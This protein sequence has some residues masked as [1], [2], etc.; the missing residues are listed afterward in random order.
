[1]DRDFG[2]KCGGRTLWR[3]L[4]VLPATIVLSSLVPL[5]GEDA[6]P[7]EKG[8]GQ[9]A[10]PFLK[11]NCLGCHDDKERSGEVVLQPLVEKGFRDHR[12][13]WRRAERQLAAK[14]MPPEDQPQPDDKEREAFLA[15][16]KKLTSTPD[17]KGADPGRVTVRRLNRAEYSYTVQDLLHVRARPH[18]EF[19][20][21]DAGYGFD[22]I[23]DV[24]TVPPILLERYLQ[25]AE[26]IANEAILDWKPIKV[27]QAATE[28]PVI[29]THSGDRGSFKVLYS[30]G[31]V[32]GTFKVPYAGEY[33]MRV[34]T[35]GDQAGPEVAKM[36]L[37]VN[38][39]S[40]KE[41]EVPGDEKKPETYEL[42]VEL[43]AGDRK[44]AAA[45]TNDYY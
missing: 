26:A 35:Y 11:R 5:H 23:G 34:R 22:R 12:G 43:E 8:H 13:L 32:E 21:D 25:A 41:L 29:D 1:M 28:L 20:A 2:T 17:E 19:P 9:V 45:F 30:N 44:L 3:G 42:K 14:Q 7:L 36:A 6:E 31:R 4:L 37:L 15:W 27:R 16:V 38:G 10:V 24:L 33:V 18:D 40:V 39:R